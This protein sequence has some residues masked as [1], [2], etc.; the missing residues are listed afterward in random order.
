MYTPL[1]L[2]LPVGGGLQPSREPSEEEITF[3]GTDVM[4]LLSALLVCGVVC[5]TCSMWGTEEQTRQNA[6]DAHIF[7]PV[8][9]A[10]FSHGA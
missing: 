8:P 10:V 4:I 1:L 2:P 5:V 3:S 9:P 6:A 7:V